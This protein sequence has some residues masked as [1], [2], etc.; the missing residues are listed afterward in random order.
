MCGKRHERMTDKQ[1]R[2]SKQTEKTNQ[3]RLTSRRKERPDFKKRRNIRL[4]KYNQTDKQNLHGE[5]K[6]TQAQKYSHIKR[7]AIHNDAATEQPASHNPSVHDPHPWLA[8][9]NQL[10]DYHNNIPD[11]TMDDESTDIVK[12]YVTTYLNKWQWLLK[13]EDEEIVTKHCDVNYKLVTE[14]TINSIS[15]SRLWLPWPGDT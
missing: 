12:C 2:R 11:P 6:K 4:N 13:E 15:T 1:T 14:D 3:E 7:I 5:T 8:S 9:Q 10:R